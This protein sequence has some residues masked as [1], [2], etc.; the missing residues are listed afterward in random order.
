MKRYTEPH[1]FEP[2]QQR[3]D[4]RGGWYALCARCMATEDA[5][6]GRYEPG[7]APPVHPKAGKR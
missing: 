2:G 7:V 1:P 6:F 4:G 5:T 3:P